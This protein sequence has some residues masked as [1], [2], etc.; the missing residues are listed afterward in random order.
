LG[1]PARAQTYLGPTP[2]LSDADGPLRL[3]KPSLED[4][5]DGSFDLLGVSADHGVV[6][7]PASNCDSVDADDGSIDGSGANGHS[8]FYSYGNNGITLTFDDSVIGSFPTSAGVVWTDAGGNASV[9][10]EAFDASGTSLGPV[11]PYKIADASNYGQT[12]EDRF[13]GIADRNGISAIKVW[14]SSGGIEIDHVQYSIG[15]L[16][17]EASDTVL[18]A[19]DSLTLTLAGGKANQLGM[20]VAL[21][22]NGSPTWIPLYTTTFDGAGEI[23]LSATVPSGLT[24]V[25]LDLGGVGIA[26]SGKVR[27]GNEVTLV[28]N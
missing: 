24:G 16:S 14:N 17:L 6:Y 10:F 3:T 21:G 26:A 5:E 4:M 28:F 2:Y 11:G 22:V 20:F 27:F 8:F 23:S 12:A 7:G 25:V 9:Y 18:S 19:N 15:A 1:A 13:F